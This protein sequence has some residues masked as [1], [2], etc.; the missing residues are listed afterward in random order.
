MFL[1][2]TE[3]VKGMPH[4][5]S[6]AAKLPW[7]VARQLGNIR[8]H[9]FTAAAFSGVQNRRLDELEFVLARLTF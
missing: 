4:D 6:T 1:Q 2:Q 9:L 8:I 3:I 7:G 5:K